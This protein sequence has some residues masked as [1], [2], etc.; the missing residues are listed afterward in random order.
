M[1]FWGNWVNLE[2]EVDLIQATE[3]KT[4]AQRGDMISLKLF[5]WENVIA[6]LRPQY[7]DSP[8]SAFHQVYC[9]LVACLKDIHQPPTE[10]E[11][12]LRVRGQCCILINTLEPSSF[13]CYIYSTYSRE[14]V[15]LCL[16]ISLSN[17]VRLS[18]QC[19]QNKPF[20]HMG[21]LI[22]MDMP[23][24]SSSVPFY[25]L[26]ITDIDTVMLYPRL[27]KQIPLNPT[28]K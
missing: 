24:L 6:K 23:V 18:T 3:E 4:Q 26:M 9:F 28:L 19:V 15:I 27:I 16:E 10:M 1:Q 5:I 8:N 7:S 11:S 20:L 13:L 22:S 12:K 2:S 14:K 21:V 25:D 17:Q